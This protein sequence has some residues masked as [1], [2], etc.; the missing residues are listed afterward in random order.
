ME[1]QDL[2][3]KAKDFWENSVEDYNKKVSMNNKQY[4]I[5]FMNSLITT[6]YFY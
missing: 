5:F 4:Y 2:H 3:L 6:I 1:F